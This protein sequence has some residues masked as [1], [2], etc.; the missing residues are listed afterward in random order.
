MSCLLRFLVRHLTYT[1]ILVIYAYS[2]ASFIIKSFFDTP[3]LVCQRLRPMKPSLSLCTY[4]CVQIGPNFY[5]LIVQV[6]LHIQIDHG[7]K[8]QGFPSKSWCCCCWVLSYSWTEGDAGEGLSLLRMV[9]PSAI[10]IP[11]FPLSKTGNTLPEHIIFSVT[12]HRR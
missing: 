5:T 2:R 3:I 12:F 8:I 6:H 9:L 4:P 1:L 11:D 7:K 10:L